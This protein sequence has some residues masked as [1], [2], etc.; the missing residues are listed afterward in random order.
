M[1]VIESIFTVFSAYYS[2]TAIKMRLRS[3]TA[4]GAKVAVARPHT[5]IAMDDFRY[6]CLD[7]LTVHWCWCVSLN[8]CVTGGCM[9]VCVNLVFPGMF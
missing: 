3:S 6:T 8:V 2:R 7:L 9:C 1:R 4:T 5:H